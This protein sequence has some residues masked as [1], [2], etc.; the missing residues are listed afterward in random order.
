[1][2]NGA[3]RSQPMPTDQIA[4]LWESAFMAWRVFVILSVITTVVGV[5]SFLYQWWNGD[6]S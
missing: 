4:W 3:Q 2:Q 1:M 5:V 6:L